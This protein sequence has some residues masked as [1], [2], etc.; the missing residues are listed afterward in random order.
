MSKY[1]HRD[2]DMTEFS[3]LIRNRFGIETRKSYNSDIE[4]TICKIL[5]RRSFR[6]YLDQEVKDELRELLLACAQSASS[7]SDLQQY[8]IID[9]RKQPIKNSLGEIS[10][11]PFIA[12]APIVLI[13]CGDS[14]RARQIAKWRG[15]PYAHNTLDNFMNAAVDAALAMQTYILAAEVNGLGC[16]PISQIRRDLVGIRDLLHLPKGVFPLAG[17]TAGWPG[18]SRDVVR[19]LPPSVVI[20]RNSY[21]ENHLEN[22]INLYDQRRHEIRPITEDN[23]LHKDEFDLPKFYGW[24]EHIARRL[25]KPSVL[26]TLRPFLEFHGFDL[27]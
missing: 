1:L 6:R 21:D 15:L 5:S 19:R 4:E 26:K 24:S 18:E 25:A 20:H 17:L 7:K 12:S 14:R 3:R 27:E 11:S 10:E 9:I 23:Y 22:E 2:G 13:F 16:C 8:S